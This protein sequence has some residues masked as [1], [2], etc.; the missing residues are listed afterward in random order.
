MRPLTDDQ[1]KRIEKIIQG[2]TGVLLGVFGG[3]KSVS[4][5]WMEELGLDPKSPSFIEQAY[6]LGKLNQTLTSSEL[7]KL[8]YDALLARIGE[9]K[10]T[11]MEQE[12]LSYAQRQAGRHVTNAERKITMFIDDAN[13]RIGQKTMMERDVIGSTVADSVSRRQTRGQLV[14]ELGR[15]TGDWTR[16]WERVANTELWDARLAATTRQILTGD[17]I[18]SSLKGKEARV[19]RRPAPDS[20]NHCKRLYLESDGVTPKIFKLHEL[21]SNGDNVGRKTAEWL[22]TVHPT[23]PNCF[24][25]GN[26]KVLTST[27]YKK[28]R[29]ITIGDSVLTHKGRFKPVVGTLAEYT[30]RYSG[31][32]YTVAYKGQYGNTKKLRVTPEHKFLTQEGWKRADELSTEDNLQML[33][34]PCEDCGE[35]FDVVNDRLTCKTCTHKRARKKITDDPE[36]LEKLKETRAKSSKKYWE[37]LKSDEERYAKYREDQSKRSSQA[38]KE[39]KSD[40]ERY[41]AFR[42]RVSKSSAKSW[43]E[44]KKDTKAMEEFSQKSSDNAKKLWEHR[45]NN[46]EELQAFA[47]KVSDT[48]TNYFKDPANRMS[49]TADFKRRLSKRMSIKN[50]MKDPDV[51]NKVRYKNLE[52]GSYER[53]REYMLNGGAT[54]AARASLKAQNRVSR[55]QFELYKLVFELYTSAI[56]EHPVKRKN[57]RFYSLDIAIPEVRVNIEYDGSYF[58]QDVEKDNNRDAELGKL[59]W[60]ILRYRDYVPTIEELKEDLNRVMSNHDGDYGFRDY[61]IE[62]VSC[63]LVTNNKLHDIT[64]ADDHSFIVEGVVSH[65]CNCPME[66]VPDGFVFDQNGDLVPE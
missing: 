17:T 35:D 51:V 14:S 28:I 54:K 13:N 29:E 23:H 20:C 40:P 42:N 39:L 1:L 2:H 26:V 56:L 47:D 32:I 37:E 12:A 53:H 6:I 19:F 58:H 61:P 11:K 52:N 30:E 9:T 57:G 65:N 38:Q 4:S 36:K 31:E 18:Y 10:L 33:T 22:P 60:T 27:G 66:A 21:I 49:H 25:D 46:P 43:E 8:T 3:G 63:E 7:S 59:G 48:L 44:K 50:P 15:A 45:R 55:P 34:L 62:G 5:E 41:E 64:V 16:D 24:V